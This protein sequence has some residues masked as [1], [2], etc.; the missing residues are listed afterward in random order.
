MMKDGPA[1][2]T[3][4]KL[5]EA[6]NRALIISAALD[7]AIAD[8]EFWTSKLENA[9]DSASLEETKRILE[10]KLEDVK[11]FKIRLVETEAEIRLIEKNENQ[12]K[13]D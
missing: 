11:E 5:Q 2:K 10:K 12:W 7:R 8:E 1:L 13:N 9:N 4:W 6:K 3:N